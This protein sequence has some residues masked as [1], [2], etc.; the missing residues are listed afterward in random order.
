MEIKDIK[1]CPECGSSNL[2]YLEDK[3]QVVCKV[4]GNIYEPRE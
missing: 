4:C 2:V 3:E 1:E